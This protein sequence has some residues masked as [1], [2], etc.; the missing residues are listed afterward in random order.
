[1]TTIYFAGPTAPPGSFDFFLGRVELGAEGAVERI[2]FENVDIP[3]PVKV[4]QVTLKG[5]DIADFRIVEDG[6]TGAT[7]PLRGHCVMEVLF[8]PLSACDRIAALI[9]GGPSGTARA[10]LTGT[11]VD[12]ANPTG[13]DPGGSTTLPETTIPTMSSPETSASTTVSSVTSTATTVPPSIQP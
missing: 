6:C 4:D 7:V 5:S 9:V 13:C 3:T 8:A 12:P 11:G 10:G 2:A 1:M